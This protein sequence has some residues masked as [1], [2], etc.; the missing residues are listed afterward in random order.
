MR[1]LTALTYYAP[2]ISGL[3]VYARRLVRRLVANGHG[4]LDV[5]AVL[6]LYEDEAV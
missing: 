3:T 6:K 2:H 1:I 5:V 4:E